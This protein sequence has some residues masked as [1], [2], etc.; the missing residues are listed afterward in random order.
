MNV[1]LTE[2]IFNHFGLAS[3]QIACWLGHYIDAIKEY[4]YADVEKI[5]APLQNSKMQI[6]IILSISDS[7]FSAQFYIQ[8]LSYKA[9]FDFLTVKG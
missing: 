8:I 5:K 2:L 7:N 4:I 9:L 1:P 3:Y 6:F